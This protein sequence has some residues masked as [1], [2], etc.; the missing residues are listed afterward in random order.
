MERVACESLNQH[1][2][3]PLNVNPER[4]RRSGYNRVRVSARSSDVPLEG[5]CLHFPKEN[6]P[7][8]KVIEVSAAPRLVLYV[9]HKRCV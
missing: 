3:G 1:Q 6:R 7:L 5:F 2:G 9:A 8:R 4:K